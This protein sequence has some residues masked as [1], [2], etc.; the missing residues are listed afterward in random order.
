MA[1]WF[2]FDANG[3]KQ[4]PITPQQLKALADRGI[5]S[6]GT[7]ME[8]DTGKKGVAGQIPGLFA[9]APPQTA[10]SAETEI[11]GVAQPSSPPTAP[12]PFTAAAPPPDVQTT[13]ER[14]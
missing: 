5:V 3:N 2:Y 14:G 12:N 6:P 1:N 10:K 4:G 13:S 7:A 11:Y 9:V 8:T